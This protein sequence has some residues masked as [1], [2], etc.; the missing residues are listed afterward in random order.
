MD[1]RTGFEARAVLAPRRP[2][3]ARLALLVPVVVLVAIAWA[4]LSGARPEQGT[5][6]RT[7]AS[8]AAPSQTAERPTKPPVVATQPERPTQVIGLEVQRLDTVQTLGLKRDDVVAVVGWYV[9]TSITDCPPLAAQYQATAPPGALRTADGWAYCQRSGVLYASP[10][11]V[12]DSWS[13]SAGL[14]AVGARL[15]A[16]VIVPAELEVIGTHATEVVVVGRFARSGEGCTV[17]AG[18]EPELLIDHVA[19]TPGA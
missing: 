11:D 14:S 4:G 18:C 9:A 15:I 7:S 8:A 12:Q 10:P 16:G 6:A 5:A 17:A 19:W 13:G 3:Q 2:R 1:D